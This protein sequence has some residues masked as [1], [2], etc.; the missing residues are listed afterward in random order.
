MDGIGLIDPAL[1]RDLAAAAAR[2]PRTTWCIT[3]TDQHGHAIGY[4]CARPEPQPPPDANPARPTAA[5]RPA[6][7]PAPA[8][9]GSASP[10]SAGP[11]RPAD[12]GPGG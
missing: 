9:R 6:A 1:A 3:V 2:N 10:R 4:G 8:G 11:A 12:T 7:R 5:I